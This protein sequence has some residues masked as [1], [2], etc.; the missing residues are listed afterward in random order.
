MS[1]ATALR[2]IGSQLDDPVSLGLAV[3]ELIA[4]RTEPPTL[5]ALGEPTHG[6]AAFPLL[7]NELLGQ[8]VRRG[9]RSIALET[10]FFAA[11]L[12]D[13]YVNG[14]A[15][16]IE[17]V[18]ATGFSHGFGAVPGNRELVQ[19]LREYNA[20]R[21]ERDRVRFHGFDA[22]LEYSGAPSPVPSL[23]FVGDY[24]PPSLRP[25]SVRGLGENDAEEAA[26]TNPAAMFDPAASIGNSD[27][28]RDLRIVADDLASAL[29]RAAPA[30][31]SADPGGYA[32]AVAHVRTAKGLSR[33]HA[34]MATPSPE[35]VGALRGLRAEMMAENLL[36]IVERERRRGPVLAF[37]HNAHLRAGRSRMPSGE[38]EANWGSAGSLAGLELGE[39]Y[40]FV[41]TDAAPAAEPG[42]LQGLL[43]AA[44]DRRALFPVPALLTAL[45]AAI[46]AGEPIVRGHLPLNPDELD[47][48]DAVVFVADTDGKRHGFW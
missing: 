8:L 33:Y 17:D 6:I 35:R 39:R 30:L 12:V 28:A 19:W 18:L 41:A 7:R 1:T 16:D 29:C 43:A 38:E 20:D 24:L 47:G 46:S 11:S 23:R 4:A 42:T 14:A 27:R 36:A 25:R 2:G 31:R 21:E 10:D 13:D 26:W 37:A 45:P 3:D 15:T 44:T 22:P 9:Y 34:A 48:T 40:L 32:A 5:L